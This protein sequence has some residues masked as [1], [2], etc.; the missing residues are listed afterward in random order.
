MVMAER[1][2]H[3]PRR[4]IDR[5]GVPGDS[6]RQNRHDLGPR[7][8]SGCMRWLGGTTREVRDHLPAMLAPEGAAW[9]SLRGRSA[10]TR[11]G[12]M[13]V[14]CVPRDGARARSRR[15]R[16][17]AMAVG[18]VPCDHVRGPSRRWPVQ[19]MDAFPVMAVGCLIRARWRSGRVNHGAESGADRQS[20][21]SL[22][23]AQ[24]LAH[25][26]RRTCRLGKRSCCI[27]L[28]KSA[29]SCRRERRRLY[30]LVRRRPILRS[31]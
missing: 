15:F 25:Q 23:P 9:D 14:G 13:T 4:R 8:S 10:A 28:R 18:C 12:A 30:G 1:V 26:P 31:R 6:N 20:D 16:S 5:D 11:L 24:R 29:R 19:A 2:A 27:Q 7:A 3:Q 21:G 22:V 17:H